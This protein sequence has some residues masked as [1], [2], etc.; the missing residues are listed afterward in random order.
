M[1]KSFVVYLKNILNVCNYIFL[2]FF[3]ICNFLNPSAFGQ[4][5]IILEKKNGIYLVPC[6]VNGLNMK[7]I[8]DSGASDVTISLVEAMFMIKNNY[9]S[10]DKILGSKEYLMANGEIQEGTKIILN[11]ITIGNFEIKNVEA[12]IVHNT[13]APLLLGQ[14]ALS[15]LGKFS[16]DYTTNSLIIGNDT[17][18]NN[19]VGCIKD[20]CIDGYG[21]IIYPNGDKYV[22]EF[23]DSMRNG[24]GTYTFI[25]G[26]VYNGNFLNGKFNGNG[27]LIFSNGNKYIGEFKDNNY[28]GYGTYTEVDGLKYVG[29]LK[30]NKKNGKGTLT[31]K[32]GSKYVGEF[33]N[34]KYDGYGT[35]TFSYGDKYVGEFKNDKYDGYG[36]YMYANGKIRYGIYKDGICIKQKKI[37][38]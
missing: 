18:I 4:S 32:D 31:F 26:S 30:D 34:D 24:I 17:E 3:S 1:S 22:G 19:P 11:S 38:K 13:K 16:F 27:T 28:E 21:T 15:K 35:Y 8:F 25:S 6:Q 9:L 2:I 12:S 37:K 33:K 10:E 29:E 20:N 23:K 7:F 36:T 5:R 14:S